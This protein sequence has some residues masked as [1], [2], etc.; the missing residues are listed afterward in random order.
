VGA[1]HV[2]AVL[3]LAGGDRTAREL[4][5]PGRLRVRRTSGRLAFGPEP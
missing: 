2:R 4:H 5:L 1:A 3:A